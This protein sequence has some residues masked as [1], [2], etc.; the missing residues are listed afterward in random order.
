MLCRYKQLSFSSTSWSPI[1]LIWPG[2]MSQIIMVDFE[3]F[4][5][6]FNTN[7][8]MHTQVS[9]LDM[10]MF[11]ICRV[12]A[13][14]FYD[15]YDAISL[16]RQYSHNLLIYHELVRCYLFIILRRDRLIDFKVKLMEVEE[17]KSLKS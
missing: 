16:F 8:K 10:R 17:N 1:Y 14:H 15:E 9:E 2:Q 3:I 11:V 13:P 6:F 4:E 12:I 5:N 7:I